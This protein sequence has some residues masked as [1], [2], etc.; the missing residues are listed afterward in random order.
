MQ[1]CLS[2]GVVCLFAAGFV[3]CGGESGSSPTSPTPAQTNRSPVINSMDVSPSFGVA[4][5]TSFAFSASASDPD[6]DSVTYAWDLAGSAYSGTSG[7]MTFSSGAE[8]ARLTVSDGKGGSTSETRAFVVASPAGSWNGS[9][10]LSSCL[11]YSKVM[12][13]TLSQSLT[14]VTGTVGLPAGLC[15]FQPGTAVT[16]PAEPGKIDANGNVTIRI[17]IP[18]YTDVT[19]KGT[20]DS[21]GRRMTGG[22]YG[23]GHTGTPVVLTKQ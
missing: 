4:Q 7:S 9:V 1:R 5:L 20:I 6:G 12:T 13:A 19:F 18:P 14:V 21:T 10:D 15:S 8:G 3:G 11:G 17:K 23:S 22:L 16:D 2:V